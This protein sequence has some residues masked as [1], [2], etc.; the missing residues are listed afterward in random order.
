[1]AKKDLG[2]ASA[3]APMP[4]LII[5]TYDKD[6]NP[7]AMNV[8]WGGQCGGKNIA[9]N[10]SSHQTTD[11]LKETM[12]FTCALADKDHMVAADYVGI[13]SARKVPDKVAQA[14]LTPVKASHVNAPVFEE[15][16]IT[17]ECKV[18]YM[19]EELGETRVVGEIVNLI[20]DESVLTDEG[21]IDLTKCN[22]ISFDTCQAGY[23]ELG[24]RVGNAFSDGKQLI[25]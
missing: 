11:N 16:P 14:G 24:A 21:K 9:L 20:A 15:F 13:V 22:L 18:L 19:N 8:A 25:K 2:V 17:M 10:L 23:L 6:G 12:A 7:D 5:G 4:V 1:M 3:V